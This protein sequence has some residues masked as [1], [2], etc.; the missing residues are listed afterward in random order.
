MINKSNLFI[1]KNISGEGIVKDVD[2]KSRIIS[3]YY[4]SFDNM[5]S[6]R[7]VIRNG[8][9]A[10]SIAE[11]GPESSQPRI[12]HLYQH[13]TEQPLGRPKI[14]KEDEF[15]LYF[16][17]YISKTR[18][19]NDVL[20][21]YK[22]GVL[23]EHSIGFNVIKSRPYEEEAGQKGTEILEVRLWEGSTVTFGANEMTPFLGFKDLDVKGT[24]DAIE[25]LTKKLKNGTLSDDTF[26]LLE[27]EL[28][29]L[30]TSLISTQEPDNDD[31]SEIDEPK[32]HNDNYEDIKNIFDEHINYIKINDKTLWN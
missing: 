12:M 31:H 15:G 29:K 19:G 28:Q 11:R 3:G 2:T 5:D 25:S 7:D 30:K 10:K 8:A 6:D 20:E 14:L 13:K 16:E 17:T 18:L 27:I 22:D 23:N 32:H 24:L 21:L 1:T 26:V 4:S 9:F